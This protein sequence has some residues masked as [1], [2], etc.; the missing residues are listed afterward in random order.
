MNTF[1]LGFT[2]QRYLAI[3]AVSA[4][5]PHEHLS[6]A[7]KKTAIACCNYSGDSLVLLFINGA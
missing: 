3:P 6:W 7:N 5:L 1:N 2:Q 4:D